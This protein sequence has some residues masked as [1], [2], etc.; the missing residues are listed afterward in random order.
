[1]AGKKISK[2]EKI[3][4][5]RCRGKT[6]HR[7]AIAIRGD[8]GTESYGPDY[9]L[10]WRTLYE[11]LQCSGCKEAVLRSTT[12]TSESEYSEVRYFPPAISRHPPQWKNQLPG[13][14][15]LLL[16]EV[17]RSLDAANRR[18]PMMG[19]RTIVDLLIRDKVGDIGG[20]EKKLEKLESEKYISASSR[21]VLKAVLGVGNAAAH[22]GYAAKKGQVDAVMD[23]VENLLQAIYVFPEMGDEI[24]K[25]TPPRP[26][27]KR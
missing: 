14:I 6:W 21:G 17:Y 4:C 19:A 16:D 2:S 11:V 15:I 25:S 20:F 1:M 24:E 23:I 22:R 9:D 12:D 10:S 7:L 5:N 3:H 27:A 8:E 26:K 13:E 18:L